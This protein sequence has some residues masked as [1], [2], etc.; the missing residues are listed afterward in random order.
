MLGTMK[1]QATNQEKLPGFP[2]H[3]RLHPVV[4]TMHTKTY[5]Y[6]KEIKTHQVP[7][8]SM[9]MSKED[10]SKPKQEI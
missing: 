2:K 4:F 5:F 10:S 9:L 8:S 6:V 3:F 1:Q 7:P